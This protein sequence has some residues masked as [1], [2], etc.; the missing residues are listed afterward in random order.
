MKVTRILYNEIKARLKEAPGYTQA[1]VSKMVKVAQD[2]VGRV[3]RS[4]NYKN[5]HELIKEHNLRQ[6][7]R[8]EFANYTSVSK[9]DR[10]E[11]DRMEDDKKRIITE[12]KGHMRKI[13]SLLKQL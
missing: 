2:T 4:R 6:A 5:Y 7:Q 1:E 9:P 3:A 13:T 10:V 8:K 11:L 12:I